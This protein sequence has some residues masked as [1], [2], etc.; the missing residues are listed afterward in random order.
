MCAFILIGTGLNPGRHLTLEAVDAV[1]SVERV[2]A[3]TYTS[4]MPDGWIE[5]IESRTGRKVETLDRVSVEKGD[6][7]ISACETGGVSLL[8]PGDPLTATTHIHLIEEMEKRNIKVRVIPGVSIL[9]VAPGLLGLQAYKFGRTVSLPRWRPG[10]EPV[11]PLEHILENLRLGLHT[12]IL[13]D[14]EPEPMSASEAGSQLLCMSERS[15]TETLTRDTMIC[16]VARACFDDQTLLYLPLGRL[17]E[18]NPGPP[19]HSLVIPGSLHFIEKQRLERIR[20]SSDI[21]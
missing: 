7:L 6:I 2:F 18:V 13:L 20:V 17:P 10:F 9:S 12:L 16:V 19:P 15:G 14:T 5:V 3:E 1:K 4:R 21:A 8:V 11:S